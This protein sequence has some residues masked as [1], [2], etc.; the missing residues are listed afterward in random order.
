M[1]NVSGLC[2]ANSARAPVEFRSLARQVA[3]R[4]KNGPMIEDLGLMEAADGNWP[5]AT[6]Y[7]QQARST[8]TKREDI[9]RAVLHEAESWAKQGK[10]KRGVDAVRSVLRIVSDAPT[11]ALFKKVEQDLSPPAPAPAPAAPPPRR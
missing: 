1:E 2:G 4:A 11:I 3:S 8:Y 9:L 10:P 6:S 7:F 5:A